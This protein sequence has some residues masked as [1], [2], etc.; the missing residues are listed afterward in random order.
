[1]E[2]G[3]AASDLAFNKAIVQDS[4][5]EVLIILIYKRV[6]ILFEV[7]AD[8]NRFKPTFGCNHNLAETQLSVTAVTWPKLKIS[9]TVIAKTVI[10]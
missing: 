4:R 10:F 2:G 1:M 5:S 7:G 6:V 8:R 9:V 3:Y